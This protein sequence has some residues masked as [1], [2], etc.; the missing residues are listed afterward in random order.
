MANVRREGSSSVRV[1]LAQLEGLALTKS[2]LA[3]RLG[4]S[5]DYV[6]RFLN[7]RSPFPKSRELLERLAEV[8]QVD[9]YTF[10]EYRWHDEQL[11]PS[12]RL[13]WSRMRELSMSR[14]RLF[15]ALG[16]RISRPYFNSILRGDQ[17]FPTNRAFIQLFALALNLPPSAFREFGHSSAPRWSA[18]ALAEQEVRTFGL[19]FDKMMAEYGFTPHPVPLSMLDEGL[20]L[21][22]FM[23]RDAIMPE[24]AEVL[25]RM[26]ELGMGFHELQRVSGVPRERLTGLFSAGAVRIAA[27]AEGPFLIADLTAVREALRLR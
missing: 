17:P 15:D 24:L 27:P 23:E 14:D 16:G 19:F 25:H 11:S 21:A 26:G 5:Q 12:T 7:E 13:V 9:P 4:V 20:V 22:F 2:E 8:C 1:V 18:D 3:R 10:V 6:Y